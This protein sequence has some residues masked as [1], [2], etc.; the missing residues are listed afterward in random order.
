M[1]FSFSADQVTVSA[2]DDPE[3]E[4]DPRV[5]ADL[6]REIFELVGSRFAVESVEILDD[7]LY[8]TFLGSSSGGGEN[9]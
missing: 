1:Q 6:E 8:H 5:I 3:P 9:Q 2:P 7:S 4:I